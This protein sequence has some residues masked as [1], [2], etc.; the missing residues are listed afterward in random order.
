V[1]GDLLPPAVVDPGELLLDSLLL[2]SS[3]LPVLGVEGVAVLHGEPRD[4]LLDWLVDW[5]SELV[6]V[7]MDDFLYETALVG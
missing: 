3:L 6:G 7:S 5:L 2:D 4:S 1:T